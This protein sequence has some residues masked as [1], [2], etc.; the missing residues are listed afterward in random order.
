M[1]YVGVYVAPITTTPGPNFKSDY[2]REAYA[3]LFRLIKDMGAEP[4]IVHSAKQTY[5]GNGLFTEYWTVSFVDEKPVYTKHEEEIQLNFLYDKSR[6]PFDDMPMINPRVIRAITD[7]KYLS[8]QFAPEYHPLSFLVQNDDEMTAVRLGWPDGGNAFVALKELVGNSGDQVYVG[9]F[10]E[11]KSN[12]SYPLIAQH[13]I[14]TSGGYENLAE[15][16]H[17]MRVTAYNGTIINGQL[18][19]PPKDG[20]LANIQFGGPSTLLPLE[21]IP[22]ELVTIFTEL[23][24]K[25]EKYGD[26]FYSADFGYNG[27]EWLLFELNAYPGLSVTDDPQAPPAHY[28]RKLAENLIESA[29]KATYGKI[30]S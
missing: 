27:K 14:D 10:N 20:L 19:V 12:L 11:Y 29:R 17:D 25:L 13:F 18:R 26:R 3:Y 22:P 7:N 8:Y 2:Y 9:P 1:I 15:G 16:R 28:M 23:D 4:I 24:S 6:F 21:K 5:K 30:D